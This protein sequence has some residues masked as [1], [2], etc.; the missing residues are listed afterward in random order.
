MLSAESSRL[1]RALAF[2]RLSEAGMVDLLGMFRRR[3]SKRGKEDLRA[4][5]E[6]I[7]SL[8]DPLSSCWRA[9]VRDAP[10]I[11]RDAPAP[12]VDAPRPPRAR[13]CL[14]KCQPKGQKGRVRGRSSAR[15][16]RSQP[17][18]QSPARATAGAGRNC[19]GGRDFWLCIAWKRVSV[20][21]RSCAASASM[22]AAAKPSACSDRTAPA[23]PR[24][25]T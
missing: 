4:S 17:E 18:P 12:G 25:S 24:C 8:D 1:R 19:Y 5:R 10:P 15:A 22:C 16:R 7:T 20:R 11:A 23:R 2:E 6:D 21:A 3:P 13:H 9:A 14:R